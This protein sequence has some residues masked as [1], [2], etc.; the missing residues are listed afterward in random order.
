M[1]DR[2]VFDHIN[3]RSHSHKPI[4]KQKNGDSS[5][6]SKIQ[7][8]KIYMLMIAHLS[9][10]SPELEFSGQTAAAIFARRLNLF[11]INGL[12]SS[13]PIKL[14]KN[15]SSESNS[16]SER[17]SNQLSIGIPLSTWNPNAWNKTINC[18][19]LNEISFLYGSYNKIAMQKC[20]LRTSTSFQLKILP[21][22][23]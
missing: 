23:V 18:V 5:R 1:R 21:V 2:P 12:T 13:T 7:V 19:N 17:S 10:G 14:S 15:G 3:F 8:Q 16:L 4:P 20:H 9:N 6:K 22:H 11:A